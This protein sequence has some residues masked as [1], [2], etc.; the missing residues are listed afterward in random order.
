M[1]E[2]IIG[3]NDKTKEL[4]NSIR[5]DNESI[6]YVGV[7]SDDSVLINNYDEYD[8]ALMIV[9][10]S[11]HGEVELASK[12]L[13]STIVKYL[14]KVVTI[15]CNTG[16]VKDDVYYLSKVIT[17]VNNDVTYAIESIN[18]IISDKNM[19]KLDI[20]DIFSKGRK[21]REFRIITSSS[22]NNFDDFKGD[23]KD[24]IFY[25]E[26]NRLFDVFDLDEIIKIS[27]IHDFKDID[28]IYCSRRLQDKIDDI[29]VK[30]LAF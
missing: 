2:L 30:I 21:N 8:I 28:V 1:K 18:E 11:K 4:V 9:D 19:I 22:N 6:D 7:T 14:L 12:V 29:N 10:Y 23:I 16:S 20:D 25:V 5:K 13:N 26:A 27:K 24:C 17:Y 3:F 15:A